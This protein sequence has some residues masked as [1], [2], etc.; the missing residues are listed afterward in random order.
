VRIQPRNL[1]TLRGRR[2]CA[3]GR[4][5]LAATDIARSRRLAGVS[6]PGHAPQGS[7]SGTPLLGPS[8]LRTGRD[9]FPSS[10]SSTSNASLRRRGSG[11]SKTQAVDPVMALG[12]KQ[13][14]VL[15]T[16]LTTLYPREAIVKA[17]SGETGDFGI[18]HR[19]KTALFIPEKAKNTRTLK[20]FQHMIRFAFLEVSFIGGIVRIRVAS[21]LDMSS[22][23]SVA[24][25]SQPHFV[26]LSLVITC[27]SDEAPVSI[28]V[29]LKVFL[30]DPAQGFVS[31]S[32]SGPSPQTREDFVIHASKR[33]LTHDV[34]MIIGPTSNLGVELINQ[35]GGR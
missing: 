29:L 9:S 14:T 30:L 7:G 26:P 20:C 3:S 12:M 2:V 31:V 1:V 11:N 18:A 27:L 23:G 4:Q 34:P 21:N 15:S 5:Y 19:A 8:P 16:A 6:S 13:D 35:S 32:S 10:G 25:Q 24:S 33:A 28:P 17:P 22:N